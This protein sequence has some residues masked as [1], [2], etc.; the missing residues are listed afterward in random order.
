MKN[1]V[2]LLTQFVVLSL[3]ASSMAMIL[4]GCTVGQKGQPSLPTQPEFTSPTVDTSVQ[5]SPVLPGSPEYSFVASESGA[6]ALALI[7]S[8][9]TIQTTDFGTAGKFVTAINGLT[10][11]AGH[12]WA[13]YV[14]GAYAEAGASQTI[15]QKGDTILFVYEE[16]TPVQ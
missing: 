13:F 7:E 2:K 15:L 12:Y 4:T 1:S 6:T 3:A 10:A 14:N 9:A 5:A 11:D 8:Q 16:I